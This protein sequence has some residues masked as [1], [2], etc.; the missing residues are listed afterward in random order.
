[1]LQRQGVQSCSAARPREWPGI[2]DALARCRL[3]GSRRNASCVET[4]YAALLMRPLTALP[5]IEMNAHDQDDS[6]CSIGSIAP[7]HDAGLHRHHEGAQV[8]AALA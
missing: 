1:M 7:G 2:R 3:A 6:A 5:D 4:R 8:R